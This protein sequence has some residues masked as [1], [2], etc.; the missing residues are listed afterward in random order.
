MLSIKN[1]P[2]IPVLIVMELS[3]QFA[4]SFPKLREVS[5]PG[6]IILRPPRQY[7]SQTDVC[8]CATRGDHPRQP[9]IHTNPISGG[10]EYQGSES[11]NERERDGGQLWSRVDRR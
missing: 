7:N 4:P 1:R 10:R 9:N 3:S 2:L 5:F 11:T 8:S 6:W